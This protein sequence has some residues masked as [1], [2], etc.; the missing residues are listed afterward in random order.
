MPINWNDEIFTLSETTNN[1]V[2]HRITDRIDR[3]QSTLF[4]IAGVSIVVSMF[5]IYVYTNRR[6]D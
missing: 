3:L 4:L 1:Q 5:T 6:D 2:I